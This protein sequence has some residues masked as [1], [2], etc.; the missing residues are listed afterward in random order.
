MV[1]KTQ[2]KEAKIIIFFQPFHILTDSSHI[3]ILCFFFYKVEEL[4]GGGSVINGAYTVQFLQTYLFIPATIALSS[5]QKKKHPCGNTLQQSLQ[6]K[7]RRRKKL[8]LPERHGLVCGHIV[9]VGLMARLPIRTI[10]LI[11]TF[12]FT[13]QSYKIFKTG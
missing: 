12:L 6:E 2:S 8:S 9:L 1:K 5:F 10:R 11:Q 13:Q 3:C 7:E 4:V